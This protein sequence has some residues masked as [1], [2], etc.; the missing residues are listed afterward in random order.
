MTTFAADLR[1]VG[2][3]ANFKLLLFVRCGPGTRENVDSGNR[4]PMD[5]TKPF[6]FKKKNIE[7]KDNAFIISVEDSNVRTSR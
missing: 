4:G 6:A 5:L 3:E 2:D 1:G 7:M